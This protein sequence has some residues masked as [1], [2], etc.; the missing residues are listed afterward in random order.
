[1]IRYGSGEVVEL[2]VGRREKRVSWT[3]L[4]V[5]TEDDAD[6]WHRWGG[7]TIHCQDLTMFE[8]SRATVPKPG[9]GVGLVDDPLSC[10]RGQGQ[11]IMSEEQNVI[12]RKVR[13]ETGLLALH[14]EN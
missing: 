7:R 13:V 1:M 3:A 8:A 12:Y 2:A 10:C 9:K 4:H 5:R 14:R 6:V 11:G